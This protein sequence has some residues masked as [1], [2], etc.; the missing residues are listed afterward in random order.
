MKRHI[1]ITNY[2]DWSKNMAA[3]GQKLFVEAG[4]SRKLAITP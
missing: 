2:Q 4:L 3:I 1:S